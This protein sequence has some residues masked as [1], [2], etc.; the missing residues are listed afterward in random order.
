MQAVVWDAFGCLGV[1]FPLNIFVPSETKT[2]VT[3]MTD[4][5]KSLDIAN[6][7]LYRMVM[8]DHVCPWGLKAESLLLQQ[9]ISFDDIHLTSDAEVSIFKA[10]HGVSTTPQVFF[11]DH[12]I[13]GYS[14]LAEYFHVKPQPL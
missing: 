9:G 13:G 5:C 6:V 8:S 14:E 7:R 1:L 2:I 10:T 12:R 4:T 11:G 3:A